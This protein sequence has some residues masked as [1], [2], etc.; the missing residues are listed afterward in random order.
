MEI[1]I[2]LLTHPREA[3]R[4]F[5]FGKSLTANLNTWAE[6]D[7]IQRYLADHLNEQG[8]LGITEGSTLLKMLGLLGSK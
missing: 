1:L 4:L 5:K 7:M 2:R 8:K 6:V 3:A